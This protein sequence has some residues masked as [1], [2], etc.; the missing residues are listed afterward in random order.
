M[1]DRFSG[2]SGLGEVKNIPRR[3]IREEIRESLYY[4]DIASSNIIPLGLGSFNPELGGGFNDIGAMQFMYTEEDMLIVGDYGGG[5]IY[6][7]NL[8]DLRASQIVSGV[9]PW[10]LDLDPNNDDILVSDPNHG[11]LRLYSKDGDLKINHSFPGVRD[12]KFLVKDPTKAIISQGSSL[13]IVDLKTGNIINRKTGFGDVQRVAP[14]DPRI[15]G[16]WAADIDK[17]RIFALDKDLNI[18]G[19]IIYPRPVIRTLRQNNAGTLTYGAIS[20]FWGVPGKQGPFPTTII[21]GDFNTHF[22]NWDYGA[23]Y[24][25]IAFPTSSNDIA[26]N[27]RRPWEVIL[28]Y[29]NN[30]LYINMRSWRPHIYTYTFCDADNI[31]IPAGGRYYLSIP[32]PLV[33]WRQALVRIYGDYE[34]NIDI[35]VPPVNK[36]Q[37]F[38]IVAKPGFIDATDMLSLTW[39]GIVDKFDI[40]ESFRSRAYNWTSYTVTGIDMFT[41]R[42]INPDVTAH[43][44]WRLNITL[45]P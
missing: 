24:P 44:L 14:G 20:S 19:I 31:S 29:H 18:L 38:G 15:G 25:L 35:M 16:F 1:A 32:I 26:I 22:S 27:P 33:L 8:S 12:A 40:Y 13:S 36:N 37:Q 21:Y 7:L 5:A 4:S 39:G 28:T 2:K 9:N 11:V 42:I 10:G 45:I 3:A 34:F 17:N 6:K 30:L 23:T 41:I 43:S